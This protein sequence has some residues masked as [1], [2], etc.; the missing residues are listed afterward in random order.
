MLIIV[1]GPDCAGKSTLVAQL[2]AHIKSKVG[3]DVDVLRQGPLKL[4]PL[5]AYV[6][7]LTNY[8]PGQDHHIIADRWHWGE[9]IYPEIFNRPSKMTVGMWR[10]IEMFLRSRG[11]LA[12][13]PHHNVQVLLERLKTRGDD[14]VTAEMLP[15]ITY[16]FQHVSYATYLP[17]YRISDRFT[18]GC[19][20][21]PEQVQRVVDEAVLREQAALPLSHLTTYVG[22]PS[23]DYLLVGDVRNKTFPGDTRPAFMPYGATS[24]AYLMDALSSIS[25]HRPATLGIMNACDVDDMMVALE[26]FTKIPG[27]TGA[28]GSPKYRDAPA[29]VTLGKHADKT[30]T[31]QT[32]WRHGQ[33]PHPQFVRRFFSKDNVAYGKAIEQSLITAKDNS[34]WQ[35]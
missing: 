7:P 35:H 3:G 6:M 30:F 21:P 13:Y 16:G 27:A 15:Q 9:R 24:G 32:G 33:V 4:H 8:R 25:A 28:C 11:A 34:K 31:D 17:V 1:E 2:L 10:Y 29:M 5:D 14:L 20:W 12:V 26:V 22:P 19:D 23:P 18:R